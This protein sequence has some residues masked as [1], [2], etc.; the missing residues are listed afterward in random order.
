VATGCDSSDNPDASSPKVKALNNPGQKA[1]KQKL[2]DITTE[3]D[4]SL[5]TKRIWNPGAG[6]EVT[7]YIKFD[8]LKFTVQ[9]IELT[10]AEK[11]NGYQFKGSIEYAE[12]GT[13]K[14]YSTRKGWGDWQDIP[15]NISS[16]GT[17]NYTLEQEADWYFNAALPHYKAYEGWVVKLSPDAFPPS[18]D[19]IPAEG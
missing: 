3:C 12:G 19:E 14:A 9:E 11:K 8:G 6:Y 1:L 15:E 2:D 13:S 17:P 5:V 16:D 7:E 4:G 18:C 10:E